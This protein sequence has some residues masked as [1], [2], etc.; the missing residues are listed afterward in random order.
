[1]GYIYFF[2]NK[3][4]FSI[5]QFCFYKVSVDF[6]NTIEPW[7]SVRV[8]DG[9]GFEK[10]TDIGVRHSWYVYLHIN[11]RKFIFQT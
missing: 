4:P 10:Q 1:M 3:V 11:W 7:L 9:D 5:K 8:Q 6:L 2:N